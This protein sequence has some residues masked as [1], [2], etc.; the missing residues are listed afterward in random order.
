MERFIRPEG[1]ALALKKSSGIEVGKS[2]H[3]F[4]MTF[5]SGG[6]GLKWN[7]ESVLGFPIYKKM[8]VEAMSHNIRQINLAHGYSTTRLIGVPDGMNPLISSVSDILGIGQTI[9][10]KSEVM[11]EGLQRKTPKR[12]GQTVIVGEDVL[13]SGQSTVRTVEHARERGNKVK[14]VSVLIT[15]TR[16]AAEVLSDKLGFKVEPLYTSV[17][18]VEILAEDPN[19]PNITDEQVSWVKADFEREY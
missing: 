1:I 6:T 4:P 5:A 7:V 16:R 8:I 2:A 10:K 12:E 19:C 14:G 13:T 3:E 11:A 15:R 18:L 9:Y 17:E